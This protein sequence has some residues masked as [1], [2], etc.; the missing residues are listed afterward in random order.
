[1]DG[2]LTLITWFSPVFD[3]FNFLKLDNTSHPYHINFHPIFHHILPFLHFFKQI[4]YYIFY[5][6]SL[7][8]QKFNNINT[9]INKII[10]ILI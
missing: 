3:N 1:M 6:F 5:F 7:L 10:Y 4:W 2:G 9:M 8:L